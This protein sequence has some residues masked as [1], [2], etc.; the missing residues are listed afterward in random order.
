MSFAFEITHQ[1]PDS[2]AR[3]GVLT[4]PHGSIE[5]PN[6]IFCGT[7]ASIKGLTPT[8]MRDCQTDIILSNTYHL[9]IQPGAE[10][11]EKMGGLHKFMGWDGPM[12]TDSGGFQI[13]SLGHGSVADEIKGR[14]LQ[15]RNKSVLKITEEGAEF[16]SYLDGRKIFLTPEKSI[17]IQRK[18]GADL[19]VQ[20]DECTP[21]HVDKDYTAR[22]MAMSMRWG[23][24][25]LAEWKRKDD[26]RQ[27]MYGIVQGGIYPDLR[28]ECC[29]WLQNSDF[30][31][32]AVG[33]SL[34]SHKEQMYEVVSYCTP[35]L[36]EG[37][38]V[39]LLGIGGFRDIFEGV[40]LGM[41]TF[42]CV[43]PT[44]L[45]RHGWALKKG[46]EKERINVRNAR[47]K[48]DAGPVDENCACP[49]CQSYSLSYLNH[50]FRA[51]EMLG[52]QL[53]SL[54]NVFTMNRLMR[55]LR[56]ALANDSL[57]IVEKEW[58]VS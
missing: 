17:D 11:I 45:A 31:G 50:L 52:M 16:R 29:E 42:D 40:K 47:F 13:F 1:A 34:G 14:G 2:H 32:T 3:L 56:T 33:G 37:R 46:A 55:E 21:F 19:I 25:S 26:G 7:K 24:R 9:M 18:L 54:H 44:R 27:V 36:P 23:D 20:L 53:L 22:S 38:P 15:K 58:C 35:H 48:E 57:Q 28:K 43:S 30:F 10:L 8:Q 49:C 5:T 4:T 51:G 12:L 41:D 6:F 39:H